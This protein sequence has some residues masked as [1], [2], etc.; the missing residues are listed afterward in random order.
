MSN[1]TQKV[2]ISGK[3]G[4]KPDPG[5]FYLAF[6]KPYEVLCQF[7][8]EPGSNKHTLA[9]FNFPKDVYPVGRLDY[10]S[11]GLLL[12]SNDGRLNSTLLNPENS[13]W[14][15]YLAQIENIPEPPALNLLRN[16]VMIEGRKTLPAEARLLESEPS[17]P[18]RA[19]PIRFRKNI[20][21]AW[22][23][24]RLV[25]GRNRQVRKMTAAV[26]HP[27]LRLLRTRIGEF[28]LLRTELEPGHWQHLSSQDLLEIFA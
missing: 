18:E 2:P 19:R 14:R 27:T 3:A 24:L 13:H 23:E 20:P 10:D 25:E 5:R 11:E 16:G 1:Y 12:L 17:L 6:F 4:F 22:L 15:T 21:T 28:D 9:E 7:T 26:G 8:K